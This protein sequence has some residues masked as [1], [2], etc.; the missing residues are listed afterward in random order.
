MLFNSFDFVFFLVVVFSL[1][2]F[3]L[4]R[5]RTAQNTLL[6]IASYVFYG[7]WDWRF[8]S[9][10][11][12]S[13]VCDYFIGLALHSARTE[14]HRFG[15]LLFSLGFNLG[16]L[17]YFKYFNFFIDSFAAML[18]A[19]GIP[20][21]T[22]TLEILLPVGISFYTFQTL[23]YSIDIYRRNIEPT[24]DIVAFFAFVAF[25]PQLVAGPIERASRLLPQFLQQ[26]EFAYST[27]AA[28][29]RQIIWGLFKKVVVADNCAIVVDRI[30]LDAGTMDGTALLIGTVFFAFQIYGDFSGYSDIAIGTGRLFGFNLMQNFATPYFSRNIREFWQRWHISLS[31]WFRD[32]IYIPLGGS[33][34]LLS[35]TIRNTMI[36]F[37]LSGLWHGANWTFFVWGFL[38][39]LY[40]LPRVIKLNRTAVRQ[41]P[42]EHASLRDLPQIFVTF[43]LIVFAWVFF[44]AQDLTEAVSIIARILTDVGHVNPLE[45]LRGLG[46]RSHVAR[47][48][49]AIS[50]LLVVEWIQRRRQHGLEMDGVAW[51]L[52]WPTYVAVI[53]IVLLLRHTG[54]SLEF[55]YFQF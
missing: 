53:S 23:S 12:L 38:N 6:L 32:Y 36:T 47:G 4:S 10:I 3:V 31:T 1:Y 5:W 16:L 2:W 9:L 26:R 24:R 7:W 49:A 28:G 55:I 54:G 22:G 15:L 34:G 35:A 8:L 39:G 43:G 27:A 21:G 33:R 46:L 40:L 17:G 37:V 11:V 19:L 13:S 48:T 14:R 18:G 42:P 50:I 52:R 44:R 20:A 51:F 25:F 30:Y 45:S 29:L 41:T